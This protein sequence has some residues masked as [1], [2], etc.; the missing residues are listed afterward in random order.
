MVVYGSD[1]E[2]GAAGGGL[3]RAGPQLDTL[4]KGRA[5][6]G[7]VGRAR[8]GGVPVDVVRLQFPLQR[9]QEPLP[10]VRD[11]NLVGRRWTGQAA[12]VSRYIL[13]ASAT[14]TSPPLRSPRHRCLCGC[15]PRS[16]LVTK[17]PPLWR[18]SLRSLHL[19][20]VEVLH[21]VLLIQ[22]LACTVSH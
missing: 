17:W 20:G 10:A 3:V 15:S 21:C 22:Y 5:R 12:R 6:T 9:Q 19:S 13:P 4:V 16:R 8:P 2:E 1:T 18:L 7:N 11:T 14:E